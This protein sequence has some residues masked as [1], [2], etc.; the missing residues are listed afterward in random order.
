MLTAEKGALR[1]LSVLSK[2]RQL[3]CTRMRVESIEL[4]TVCE[5]DELVVSFSRIQALSNSPNQS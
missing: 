5:G 4:E 2:T 3:S 1:T